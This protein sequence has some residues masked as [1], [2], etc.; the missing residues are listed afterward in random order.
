M[1]ILI[2]IILLTSLIFL[3]QELIPIIA[4]V[5]RK[6]PESDEN[7]VIQET[8]ELTELKLSKAFEGLPLER[9]AVEIIED[10]DLTLFSTTGLSPKIYVS[11][12]LI[13]TFNAE[14]LN[15]ALAHEIAHI[16]RSRRPILI[17]AY[18]FRI[19]M[20]FNPVAMFEFRRLAQEEENVCDRMAVMMTGKPNILIE[21]VD[22][23]R[24]SSEGGDSEKS[25]G[26]DSIISAVE[27]YSHD[28]QL[29][30]RIEKIKNYNQEDT[31]GWVIP[32]C[33]TATF[34]V[35]LN[36]YIV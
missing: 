35:L 21:A 15:V 12:G 26:L 24:S 4:D 33:L 14:H 6:G 25:K 5:I 1:F 13:N 28:I 8:D 29:I 17:I 36:Y 34:I 18:L 23:L 32:F 10:N 3:L 22:M 31:N 7:I 2:V 27:N 11:T 19:I 20:F 9:N 30:N 16:K